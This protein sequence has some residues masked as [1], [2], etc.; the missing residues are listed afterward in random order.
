[1]S[2]LLEID[3]YLSGELGEAEA[4]ALEDAL[5]AAPE[6]PDLEF[7]DRLHRH[8]TRLAAHG[9]YDMG[10]TRAQIDA[11]RAAGHTIQLVDIGPPGHHTVQFDRESE[12]LATA[13][14]LG[15]TDLEKVDV[16]LTVLDYNVTKTIRDGRVDKDGIIYGLCERPLAELAFNAGPTLVRVLHG[17]TVIG[18]WH[19]TPVR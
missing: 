14:H 2:R 10:T 3:A 12:L 11:L 19:L 8:A 17:D 7:L 15:R 9:T 4:D 1:V 6:D 5:F 16:E 13:L 18:T